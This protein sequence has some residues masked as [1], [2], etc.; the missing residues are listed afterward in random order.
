MLWRKWIRACSVWASKYKIKWRQ[1]DDLARYCVRFK[2]W[3]T[4]IPQGQKTCTEA[5]TSSRLL[6]K[7][8]MKLHIAF[9][10][11]LA[12]ISVFH[13][14]N[15]T[16]ST[17]NIQINIV[18]VFY[19]SVFVCLGGGEGD[20]AQNVSFR[21]VHFSRIIAESF[22]SELLVYFRKTT[23]SYF[24]HPHIYCMYAHPPT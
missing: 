18:V 13:I 16:N 2:G 19:L 6:I 11:L 22:K 24:F 9:P 20:K 14:V 7:W 12:F 8:L 21:N 3:V 10:S 4:H 23:L 15:M 5:N 17:E 1:W